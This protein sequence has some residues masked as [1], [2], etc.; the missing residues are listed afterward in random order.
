ML[1]P[2]MV[3]CSAPRRIAR[4]LWRSVL[5][6]NPFTVRGSRRHYDRDTEVL[7][8]E[9][10]K[11]EKRLYLMRSVPARRRHGVHANFT[12]MHSRHRPKLVHNGATVAT[13]RIV[14]EA[15]PPEEA[16]SREEQG[17][18]GPVS[19]CALLHVV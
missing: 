3:A 13:G 11:Q 5:A 17:Y 19:G 2:N 18:R 10:S 6:A 1:P 7:Y 12:G 14:I 8:S 9:S 16:M 4:V 15:R